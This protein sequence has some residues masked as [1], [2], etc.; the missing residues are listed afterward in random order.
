M[1]AL[2]IPYYVLGKLLGFEVRSILI[3][4]I[5]INMEKLEQPKSLKEIR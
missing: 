2:Y 4:F 3:M 1:S 5:G